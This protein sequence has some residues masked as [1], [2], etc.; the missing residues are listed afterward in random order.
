MNVLQLTHVTL[1]DN[2]ITGS[3]PDSWGSLTKVCLQCCMNLQDNMDMLHLALATRLAL[4]RALVSHLGECLICS[5]ASYVQGHTSCSLPHSMHTF[6][7]SVLHAAHEVHRAG[8]HYPSYIQHCAEVHRSRT[9]TKTLLIRLV[10]LLCFRCIHYK[11]AQTTSQAP[12]PVRG[13]K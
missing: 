10:F 4:C 13:A 5:L 12:C 8:C 6:R 9:F 3:L 7:A 2:M 1:E 11:S